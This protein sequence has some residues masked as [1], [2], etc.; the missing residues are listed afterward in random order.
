V[1]SPYT[2]QVRRYKEEDAPTLAAIYYHTIHNINVRDYSAEQL[3]VWAPLST[4]EAATWKRK[5]AETQRL[6]LVATIINIPV[7]FIE[8]EPNGHIDCF[9]CHPEWIRKGIGS[10]L[11]Q[12]LERN[13]KAFHIPRLFAEV[14]ITARP[15]FESKGFQ[16][17]KEQAV[18]RQGISLTNFAMEKLLK[19]A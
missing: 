1:K 18:I 4:L 19:P 11:M 2:I 5:W 3:E 10:A 17:I 13:A 6:V 15:F 9:Y 7:G 12:A 8:L 14:S 16:V